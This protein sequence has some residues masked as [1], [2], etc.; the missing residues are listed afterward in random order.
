MIDGV[1]CMC[2]QSLYAA[3]PMQQSDTRASLGSFQSVQDC[4]TPLCALFCR[5]H[6]SKRSKTAARTAALYSQPVAER[7]AATAQPVTWR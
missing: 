1:I 2:A 5:T 7:V 3:M 6:V 4:C